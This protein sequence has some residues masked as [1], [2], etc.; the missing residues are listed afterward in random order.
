MENTTQPS[1]Q[2]V[3]N[4]HSRLPLALLV[5]GSTLLIITILYSFSMIV[6]INSLYTL[7][8]GLN[9]NIPYS[10]AQTYA[11]LFLIPLLP[12]VMTMYGFYLYRKQK[13]GI[14]VSTLQKRIAIV[15]IA[16]PIIGWALALPF[17]VLSAVRPL[18]SLSTAFDTPVP[19]TVIISPPLS[20][21]ENLTD[22]WKTYTNEDFSLSFKY[23]ANQF[24]NINATTPKKGYLDIELTES[25]DPLPMLNYFL[26][27]TAVKTTEDL[28]TYVSEKEK[29]AGNAIQKT[30]VNNKNGFILV[31]DP[32]QMKEV[33]IVY[34]SKTF[35]K[36]NNTIYSV[37][38]YSNGSKTGIEKNST[39]VNQ[40][41]S[42]FKF[43]Q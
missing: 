40:I 35:L 24:P 14:V 33:P 3:E 29:G 7:Y 20:P 21:T 31:H 11:M 15:L 32:N 9:V 23:P 4:T 38:I 26:V 17:Y 36:E 2:P 10:K 22:N 42:T 1:Q 34:I 6:T 41:L 12:L 37:G 19:Q 30:I 27:V 28:E 25:N 16:L 5:I 8:E 13:H 18:Y 43:T 39:L